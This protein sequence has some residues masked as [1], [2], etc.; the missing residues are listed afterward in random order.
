MATIP[1]TT[2][3]LWQR[4]AGF[5]GIVVVF[6]VFAYLVEDAL[7]SGVTIFLEVL[8]VVLAICW[9]LFG[10]RLLARMRTRA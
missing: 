8:G 2:S 10:D 7:G 5:L 4:I 6:A 9:F 3:P 1:P